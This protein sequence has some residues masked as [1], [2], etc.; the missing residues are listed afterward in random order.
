MG[1]VFA[2]SG[3]LVPRE[4]IVLNFVL[5]G[6]DS[7]LTAQSI[8][9]TTQDMNF[10]IQAAKESSITVVLYDWNWHCIYIFR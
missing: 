10:A 5:N 1:P 2:L 7:L 8:V 6:L 4:S 9:Y 3:V